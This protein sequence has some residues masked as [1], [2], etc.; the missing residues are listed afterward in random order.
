MNSNSPMRR[1]SWTRQSGT[2][3]LEEAVA[4]YREALKENT[5][6]S[7]PLQ[8]AETQNSLGAALA[9]LGEREKGSARLTEAIAA[10]REP[11]RKEPANACRSNGP[12]P[13]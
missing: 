2:A 4:V 3:K 13:K 8:W 6:E 5:R 12:E 7:V 9:E 1:R 10:Y 11:C